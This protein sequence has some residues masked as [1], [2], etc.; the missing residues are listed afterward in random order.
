MCRLK[1]AW[2]GGISR[3]WRQVKM[4]FI[5]AHRKA[6]YTKAKVYCPIRLLCFIQKMMQKLVAKH[7]LYSMCILKI[8]ISHVLESKAALL[9]NSS[10]IVLYFDSLI[11]K[12]VAG[13]YPNL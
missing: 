3:A 4:M 2:N 1:P 5:L 10:S 11:N 8:L 9:R 12:Q 6:N 13:S 7:I